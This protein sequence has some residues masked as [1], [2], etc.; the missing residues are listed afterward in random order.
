MSGINRT[1]LGMALVS[2][3][4]LFLR[5]ELT[6]AQD[7]PVEIHRDY[8]LLRLELSPEH[9]TQVEAAL[10]QKDYKSAEKILVQEAELDPKSPRAAKLLEFSGGLFFLDAQYG[11]AV[12]AW[13][14]AEA[15][16]PLDERTRF[17]LAMAYIKVNRR[18]WARSELD[19]LSL[20]HPDDAL[21]L[22]WL[23]RIDYDDQKYSEAIARLQRI[24]ALDPNM[25]RSHDLLG[26]CYDYTGHFD[27]ALASFSRA[28]EL[29]RLQAK[30]S[31]WPPLDMAVTQIELNQVANAEKGLQ[32]AIT[33][34]PKLPQ[35][36]YQ[37]G[38]VLDKEGK[39][40]QAIHALKTSAAL[41]AGYPDPH[42]L[43]GR[44]YQKIGKND[45]AKA[46]IL[47]FQRLKEAANSGSQRIPSP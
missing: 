33:Y 2:M 47:E 41:D 4:A 43:L 6:C 45:L 3:F 8:D 31:P 12:I 30:P 29:N 39:V 46:E 37:L 22:Y 20:A 1:L 18:S 32:E 36:Q 42:Y 11:N 40:E 25:V 13:K 28:V 7:S 5:V 21:Y 17:T 14:K 15:I 35:A 38:R 10:Q 34:N 26:L 23:A 9:R 44:M 24:V 19:K 27:Q 16:A